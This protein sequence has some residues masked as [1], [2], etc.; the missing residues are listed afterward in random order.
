MAA[1]ILGRKIG[2]TR[3]FDE[4]GKQVPVTVIQAG[5][6]TVTQ[7]K[8]ED[9]DGYNAIQLAFEDVK[10]RNSTMPVIGHDGKAGI[11]PKRFHR[12]YRM[13]AE[14]LEAFEF[15]QEVNVDIFESS[16][17]VDVTGIS[18]G[19]GFQG[20][21]KKY[22]F[23]GQPATHGTERKHRSPGS[24]GGRSSNAGTGRPKKGGKKAGQMGGGQVTIR[25]LEIVARD[26][27][28]NILLVKGPVPGPRQGL[29]FVK[30]AVRL[31]KGKAVKAAEAS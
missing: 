16:R 13:D 9:T 23:K 28:K 18:K 27:D 19:F 8:T 6:C 4:S 30:D 25:S 15:G 3:L 17:F 20:A 31:F 14:A 22:R 21:M 24:V 2:M 5:P 26:K 1:A 12:E 11:S 10:G 7:I 29:L